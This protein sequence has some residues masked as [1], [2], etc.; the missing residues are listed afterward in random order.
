MHLSVSV[1]SDDLTHKFKGFTVMNEAERY[2]A[3]RHCR[4]VD[5]V[6]RD[7]PWTL[8]PEFLEKHKVLVVLPH[9]LSSKIRESGSAAKTT[10]SPKSLSISKRGNFRNCHVELLDVAPFFS[11][12]ARGLVSSHFFEYGPWS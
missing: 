10:E 4:Y 2:E 9:S 12:Q 11:A 5:E 1:C 3:L 7:A 6:I 8:T